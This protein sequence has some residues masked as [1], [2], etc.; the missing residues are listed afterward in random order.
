VDKIAPILTWN[1]PA[2]IISGSALSAT[3][4]NAV[5][6]VPGTFVYTPVAGT[7]LS[8]GTHTLHVDFTPTDAT[9]YTTAS[10]DV[11]VTVVDKIAPI[12]TWN[13]PADIIS[14][15]ALSA[16][17]LNAAADVPGIFVYTPAIGTTLRLGMHTLHVDFT[18]T[19]AAKYKNASKD[20]VINVVAIERITNGGFNIYAGKSNIPYYWMQ[21][22]FMKT[23][24]QTLDYIRE[25]DASIKIAES[26]ISYIKSLKQTLALSGMAE[27]AFTLSYWVKGKSLP[28][29]GSCKVQVELYNATVVAGT[30]ILPCTSGTFDWKQRILKFT[31]P[32]AYTSVVVKIVFNK[33]NSTVWFDGVSLIK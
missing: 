8:L 29:K 2:D 15:S 14:G 17:Q 21:S 30:Y 24:G 12:L 11:S 32:V 23:D 19:D 22:K 25:G 1:N 4:L 9:Q 28:A 18:P 10:K 20:V 13:N 3:Q 5:A 31:T 7:I 27:D 33:A 26:A 16:I 6:D